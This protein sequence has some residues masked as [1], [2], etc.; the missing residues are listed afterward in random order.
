MDN[1]TLL[2]VAMKNFPNTGCNELERNIAFLLDDLTGEQIFFSINY[3]GKHYYHET[4][5]NGLAQTVKDR[6]GE[7]L[8][9]YELAKVKQDEEQLKRSEV[10]YDQ[11]NVYQGK[12]TPS[13]FGKSINLNL[14]K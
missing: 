3:L 6:K 7:I 4:F 1:D 2:I 9:Y 11:R 13:W 8:R 10:N 12:D 14:F 5:N